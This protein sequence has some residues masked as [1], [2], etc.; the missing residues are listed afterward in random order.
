[1]ITIRRRF[2]SGGLPAALYD[3]GWPGAT[4]KFTGEVEAKLTML[5]CSDTPDGAARWTLRLLAERMIELGYVDYISHVTVRALLKKRTQALAGEVLV[6][7]QTVRTYVAKMEDVLD[8]YQRPYDPKRPVV[9]LDEAS[10]DCMPPTWQLTTEAGQAHA[11][12]LR[13]RTAWRGQ[14]LP[15]DRTSAGPPEGAVTERRTKRD[16]AEQLRLLADEDYP[17][18]TSSCWW[19]TI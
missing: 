15:G 4:P 1:V 17:T 2:L 18:P 10:K 7:R 8:V 5:A 6:Y 12:G 13:V 11:G 14:P 3:K 9:C 19:S 16:F